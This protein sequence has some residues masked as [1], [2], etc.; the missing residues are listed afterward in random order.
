MSKVFVLDTN[1]QPLQ[2]T[3]PAR[4][5]QLLQKGKAAVYRRYPFTII[6]K[7]KVTDIDNQL[8]RLKIDPGSKT[9]GLAIVNNNTGDVVFAAELEHRGQQI[10]KSMDSRRASRRGRRSRKTRYRKP[11]FNNRTRPK[12]WLPPSLMSRVVNIETWVKRLRKYCPITALSLELVKFDTQAMQHP[13]ISGIEYQQGELFGYEVRE[14][15]LEKF[16]RKCSYCGEENVPLQIEHII[17]KARG[18][19][20]RV[21]NLTIACAD[22]NRKKGTMTAGEFGYPEVQEQAKKTLKDASVV[23]STRY[24]VYRRLKEIGLP[25]EV[26]T[27]G[28]TKYNRSIR[29]L[30]K[31]HWLDAACVGASTP[32]VLD[33]EGIRPLV[34][35]AMGHGSRQMCRV[36][37]FGFPRTKAKQQKRVSG[38]QTG[39]IVQA[40]V[41]TGKKAG[42]HIGRVAV[43]SSGSFN[44][45]TELGTVQGI[46][47][48]Y[49]QLL[50][51]IDGYT[52]QR[53]RLPSAK[54]KEGEETL[55]QKI[56][57]KICPI[58]RHL[59]TL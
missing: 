53:G 41:P 39:D 52:Y 54:T 32:E 46:S 47:H 5:R 13:E 27:G 48:R 25:V 35:T 20:D 37:R 6:L 2:P 44:I 45:K 19:T 9:T 12:G 22:C 40:V 3:H 8:L 36:D 15:L 10:K 1:K 49:C 38:F 21:S 4:A 55:C 43:R 33:V 56:N 30:P 34:I 24:E 26:G 31:T 18:G 16:N 23:N 42:T 28:R 17:P 29:Q 11:R 58:S 50:H 59:M 14:Y 51:Q 57:P 7:R